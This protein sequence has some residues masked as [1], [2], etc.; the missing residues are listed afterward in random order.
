MYSILFATLLLTIPHLYLIETNKMSNK[1]VSTVSL[2]E[3]ITNLKNNGGVKRLEFLRLTADILQNYRLA[4]ES[5]FLSEYARVFS[6]SSS[7]L[8]AIRVNSDGYCCIQ[9]TLAVPNRD[10]ETARSLIMKLYEAVKK[11]NT[12][13]NLTNN[14][15]EPI[16]F[17]KILKKSTVEEMFSEAEEYFKLVKAAI[18]EMN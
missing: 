3:Y 4:T 13:W 6:E 5:S 9:Q 8:H 14:Y 17:D 10:V 16:L 11:K 18:A 2:Q 12:T 15:T 7:D 1:E